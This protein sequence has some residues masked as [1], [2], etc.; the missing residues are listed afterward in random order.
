M[1]TDHRDV[2]AYAR[3]E[4]ASAV[5]SLLSRSIGPLTSSDSLTQWPQIYRHEGVSVVLQPSEDKFLSVWVRGSEVWASCAALGRHLAKE[6][7]C[8]VRCDPEN[9]FP[10]VSPHSS[11]FLEIDGS[12]ETLVS[13]G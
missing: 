3:I 5:V 8:V 12:K 7:H 11:V 4:S 6:L 13:W 1:N 10:K 9:E 2:E